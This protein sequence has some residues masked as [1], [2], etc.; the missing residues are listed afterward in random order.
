MMTP[1]LTSA[2]RRTGS[3]PRP[4]PTAAAAGAGGRSWSF[5]SCP[6]RLPRNSNDPPAGVKGWFR[7]ECASRL[8][9]QS[10]HRSSGL[11]AVIGFLRVQIPVELTSRQLGH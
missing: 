2:S 5:F 4:R 8:L 9:G 11:V 7:A 6:R 1:A 3:P 10:E